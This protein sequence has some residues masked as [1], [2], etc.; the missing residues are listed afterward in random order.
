MSVACSVQTNAAEIDSWGRGEYSFN[1]YAD[2]V[3]FLS[4]PI[5]RTLSFSFDVRSA[6]HRFSLSV[7]TN[8]PPTKA[9]KFGAWNGP[10][11]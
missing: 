7:N 11:Y 4:S 2:V 10:R 3:A 1:Q 9:S 8:I 6:N 5:M